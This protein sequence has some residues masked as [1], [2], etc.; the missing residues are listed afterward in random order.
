MHP[1]LAYIIAQEHIAEM[2]AAAERA[3]PT[4]PDSLVLADGQRFEVRPI[5]RQD[6]ERLAGG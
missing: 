2:R 3:R 6:R 1:H 5:E 4:A